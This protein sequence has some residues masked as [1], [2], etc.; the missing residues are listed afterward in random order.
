MSEEITAAD[1]QV[2]ATAL[3][4]LQQ[5][6]ELLTRSFL[7]SESCGPEKFYRVSI[8]LQTLED[9]QKL[10]RL[11]VNLPTFVR[12]VA[13]EIPTPSGQLEG[14]ASVGPFRNYTGFEHRNIRGT[15]SHT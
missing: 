1:E 2:E 15:Q 12:Q 3:K 10:Y 11:L 7:L 5:M 14:P 13:E 8:K 4:I 6:D 9:C